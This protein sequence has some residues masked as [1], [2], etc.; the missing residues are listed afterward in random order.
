MPRQRDDGRIATTGWDGIEPIEPTRVTGPPIHK[1]R[2]MLCLCTKIISER[3]YIRSSAA[4]RPCASA[5]T[6][7][8]RHPVRFFS[9]RRVPGSQSTA[10][11]SPRSILRANRPASGLTCTVYMRL[12]AG[13]N[14]AGHVGRTPPSQ[15]PSEVSTRSC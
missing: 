4:K 9:M 7:Y 8:A 5:S 15:K 2:W 3:T 1:Q 13:T 14:A 12:T 10:Q 11:S 6:G